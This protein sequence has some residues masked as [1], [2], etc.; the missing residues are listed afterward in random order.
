MADQALY[1]YYCLTQAFRAEGP[2]SRCRAL[3]DESELARLGRFRFEKDQHLYLVAHALTRL[4]LDRHL[5]ERDPGSFRF[6]AGPHGRPE[7]V[8]APR[9]F[10]FNLSHTEGLVA[11]GIAEGREVGVDVEEAKAR[12][13]TRDVAQ[14][15]FA[16][17][18][19][20]TLDGLSEA[21]WVGRFFDFWTLKEAYLKARG[22]GLSLP[23]DQFDFTFG[24][25][26][27]ALRLNIA[28]SLNDRPER[29]QF[30]LYQVA[31][32]HR[33]AYAVERNG[34]PRVEV[35]LSEWQPYGE[36]HPGQALLLATTATGH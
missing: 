3:L 6:A 25:A 22:A 11:V 7:L 24:P 21:G 14:R 17:N 34:A 20:G 36:E 33:L 32:R 1:L 15:F 16:P 18:E 13:A 4:A 27:G 28:P 26:D 23:L 29:W 5:G 12:N 35:K 19:H 31:E 9:G 30:G 2:L 10:F 8:G